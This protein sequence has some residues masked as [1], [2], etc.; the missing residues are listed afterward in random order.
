MASEFLTLR[1]RAIVLFLFSSGCRRFEVCQLLIQD[2]D[3]DK[4]TASIR[5][6]GKKIRHVHFS[7]ECALVLT[8]YLN[9]RSYDKKEPLFMNKFGKPLGQNG[10]YK[11]IKKLGEMAGL[12]QTLHPHCCQHIFATN[13]LARGVAVGA[14]LLAAFSVNEG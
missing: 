10:I 2:V 5:G 11:I 8:D 12:K 13:M 4:R 7:I 9:T 1:D 6:K 3:L 14:N